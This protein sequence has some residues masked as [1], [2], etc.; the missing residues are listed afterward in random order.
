MSPP[1]LRTPPAGART[2]HW[3]RRRVLRAV[4]TAAPFRIAIAETQPMSGAFV[5][6]GEVEPVWALLFGGERSLGGQVNAQSQIGGT[7][8]DPQLTG[9]GALSG[10]RFED[11]PTGLKLRNVAATAD[12]EGARIDLKSFQ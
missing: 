5:L 7:L 1:T 2:S 3:S 9:Q 4:P 11:A 12:F 8:N 6:S 10:G